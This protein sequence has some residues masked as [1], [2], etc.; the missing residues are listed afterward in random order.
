MS[1]VKY[2]YDPHSLSY[3]K[4][5]KSKW[6]QVINTGVF[7]LASLLF[8]G[9]SLLFIGQ[10]IESPNEKYLKRELDNMQLNYD[11]LGRKI[12]QAESV[13]HGIQER[14][15][16][17]YRVYFE[18]DPI[19]K[20]QRVAGFGGINR[21]KRLE[22]YENSDLVIESS[23]KLDILNKQLYIQSKSL[24]EIVDLAKEKEKM[25]V[26]IP[27]IQPVANK[28]LNRM[29]S[30]YGYR[31]HPILKYRKFHS[32]MDFSAK[33]GTPIYATGDGVVKKAISGGGYGKYVV[34]DHG[35]GY[36]TLYGHMN[37]YIV[38]RRQKVKRG[39]VIGYVGNT[40]LSS[41]PHLHYEVH[42]NGKK[43][44]PVNFY[45]NDLTPEEYGRLLIM[46]Q[47]ENQS[48]D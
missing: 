28:D 26:H 33:I 40:G 13:L 27:A 21:Y 47:Q 8:G 34:I 9:L 11:L 20:E 39:E 15:D 36:E 45:H 5:K 30:G 1:K 41:G 38:K 35:Y 23:K 46:S 2:Y 12:D 19:P 6:D 22:G 17:L 7:L 32:G 37:K 10:F 14:D 29:A 24:D 25:F 44:N 4:I 48:M 31:W 16:K 42:K 43:L 3:Q 18:A